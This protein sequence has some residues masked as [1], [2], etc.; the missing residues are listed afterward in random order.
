MKALNKRGD[1]P[2]GLIIPVTIILML[3]ALYSFLTVSWKLENNSRDISQIITEVNFYEEYIRGLADEIS[4]ES[5]ESGE[6]GLKEK[7]MGGAKERDMQIKE[8]GSFFGKIRNGEFVFEKVDDKYVLN[9][10]GL[11]VKSERKANALRREFDI[12]K[13]FYVKKEPKKTKSICRVQASGGLILDYYSELHSKKIG[14]GATLFW[15]DDDFSDIAGPGEYK[16]AGEAF[17]QATDSVHT[18]DSIAISKGTKLIFYSKEN[19]EGDILFEGTGPI[20]LYN[21]YTVPGG[22]NPMGENVLKMEFKEP[23]QSEFPQSTR[24]LSDSDTHTWARTKYR[25]GMANS[26]LKEIYEYAGGSVKIEC[27]GESGDTQDL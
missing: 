1:V 16:T 21:G 15:K 12:I 6:Q 26:A 27:P 9:I 22:V 8:A 20:L 23:Y 2:T 11:F 3:L 17:L 14:Y 5:I 24:S 7:Y 18:I 25:F 4:L 10:K 13:S 19:F